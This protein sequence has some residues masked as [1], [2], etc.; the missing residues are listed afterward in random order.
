M[1]DNVKYI[2]YGT[3]YITINRE[4]NDNW[5]KVSKVPVLNLNNDPEGGKDAYI[6][7]E[8][9]FRLRI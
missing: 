7:A 1:R 9:V 6:A 5:V 3:D 8:K 2:T 4:T